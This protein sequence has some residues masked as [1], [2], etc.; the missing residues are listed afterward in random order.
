[1]PYFLDTN[2]LC[3]ILTHDARRLIAEELLRQRPVISTQVLN[4]LTNVARGKLKIE[5]PIL[6]TMMRHIVSMSERVC[7]LSLDV[8]NR[9]RDLAQRHKFHIFDANIIASAL[10]ANCD[11]LYSEDMHH[12][13]VIEGRLTIRNP[14]ID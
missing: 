12:G 9:A 6:E 13:M 11:T 10:I 5:W 2:V 3:Y 14:F 4:E 1:M 8:H 7:P